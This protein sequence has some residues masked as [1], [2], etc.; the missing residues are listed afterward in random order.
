MQ[1]CSNTEYFQR[2]EGWSVSDGLLVSRIWIRNGKMV[3]DIARWWHV[4]YRQGHLKKVR[5]QPGLGGWF[6]WQ[7]SALNQWL[8][9]VGV[10][11]RQAAGRFSLR[12]RWR[13]EALMTCCSGAPLRPTAL[14][15]PGVLG[16]YL[17]TGS[18]QVAFNSSPLKPHVQ[19]HSQVTW[20]NG[21]LAV[22]P[23]D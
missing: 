20:T 19:T 4:F 8:S 1:Y 14:W 15:Q 2:Y 18:T 6:Q 9:E 7:V 22:D 10:H 3:I 13:W 5:G 17:V 12:W 21:C 16:R 23:T 11:S